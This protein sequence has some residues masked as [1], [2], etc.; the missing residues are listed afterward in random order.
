M[1]AWKS[2]LCFTDT[3]LEPCLFEWSHHLLLQRESIL[4]R[5]NGEYDLHPQEHPNVRQ[6][7]S[8][9]WISYE[10]IMDSS[11]IL[12]L[13]FFFN[14]LAVKNSLREVVLSWWRTQELKESPSCYWWIADSPLFLCARNAR[15][16]SRGYQ[17]FSCRVIR[18][19]RCSQHPESFVL[20]KRSNDWFCR[21]SCWRACRSGWFSIFWINCRTVVL[22][23]YFT[24]ECGSPGIRKSMSASLFT[25]I[26]SWLTSWSAT[27]LSILSRSTSSSTLSVS[28][29]WHT[30]GSSCT[31]SNKSPCSMMS[32]LNIETLFVV[33]WTCLNHLCFNKSPRSVWKT[34][35]FA[36][37]T[38][39]ISWERD[40]FLPSCI[41]SSR[42]DLS[43][44]GFGVGWVGW[45]KFACRATSPSGCRAT[46]P[47]GRRATSEPNS[48][49]Q[50]WRNEIFG[51]GRGDMN[52]F[53][54]KTSPMFSLTAFGIQQAGSVSW[55][56]ITFDR[57]WQNFNPFRI[58]ML[59]ST[60]NT[61]S[62]SLFHALC[63]CC[64]RRGTFKSISSRSLW[65][66][67]IG[68]TS[69]ENTVCILLEF[70]LQ[71]LIRSWW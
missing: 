28:A 29:S 2:S 35:F 51:G 66:L 1:L 36:K 50:S 10:S 3:I 53:L 13:A 38:T 71:V 21:R 56:M 44:I 70:F 48:F 57:V 12:F 61:A 22:R 41:L 14:W 37:K 47:S 25:I 19:I 17:C 42:P 5:S 32:L 15:T 31:F 54:Y 39:L 59:M 64:A 6:N 55:R 52:T 7:S 46:S 18:I 26:D 69:K 9:F 58:A 8:K 30:W 33:R 63:K 16:C 40:V 67:S 20:M 62:W 43:R 34:E 11:E 60:Q 49:V 27:D 4:V 65:L 68:S 24:T 23:A 45:K